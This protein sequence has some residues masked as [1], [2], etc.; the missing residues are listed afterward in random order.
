MALFYGSVGQSEALAKSAIISLQDSCTSAGTVLYFFF[1]PQQ[2][3]N[4]SCR[5]EIWRFSRTL[6]ILHFPAGKFSYCT[7]RYMFSSSIQ[8]Q[9]VLFHTFLFTSAH[10][11]YGPLYLFSAIVKVL[12]SFPWWGFLFNFKKNNF[13]IQ[14]THVFNLGPPKVH[15]ELNLFS[16][17][18][19]SVPSWHKINFPIIFPRQSLHST[20]SFFPFPSFLYFSQTIYFHFLVV[21]IS[22]VHSNDCLYFQ[23]NDYVSEL[24]KAVSPLL[25]VVVDSILKMKPSVKF[26]KFSVVPSYKLHFFST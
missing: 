5:K 9:I 23:D 7:S 25:E 24:R 1:F 16:H 19:L 12:N 11:K 20:L 17:W 18:S 15:A 21:F 4:F 14:L 3:L 13:Q 8:L 2:K 26:P 22:Q 10:P 6:Q